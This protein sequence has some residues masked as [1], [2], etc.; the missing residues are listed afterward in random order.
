MTQTTIYISVNRGNDTLILDGN[1]YLFEEFLTIL[2]NL[3]KD[4]PKVNNHIRVAQ[5]PIKTQKI[6]PGQK[7]MDSHLPLSGDKEMV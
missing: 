1:L 2:N 4:L 6:V 7:F 5:L 3:V